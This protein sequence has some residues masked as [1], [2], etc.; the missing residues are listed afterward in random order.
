[1]EQ[2]QPTAIQ[3]LTKNKWLAGFMLFVIF[4]LILGGSIYCTIASKRIAIED[5]SIQAP[6]VAL[7]PNTPGVL[8]EVFVR[9]GDIILP[10]SVVAR[11]G[12]E[13]VKS[14]SGGIITSVSNS[15]GAVTN[16]ASPVV[17]MV[18]PSQ[19]RV[20]G[21]LAEDKG[22]ANV[23]VGQRATFTIDTFGS[24]EY[25]GVVD[26]VSAVPHQAGI[27]FSISDARTVKDFDIKVRF[28]VSKYPELKNGMSAKITVYK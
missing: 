4:A 28:D 23:E 5:A 11:V 25:V 6:T 19:L 21:Q 3:R 18:N 12:N 16:P 10:N 24:K 22:L 20:V 13:L 17:T 15:I 2:N 14:L 26:E 1:M 8:Q 7:S 27:A 9:E